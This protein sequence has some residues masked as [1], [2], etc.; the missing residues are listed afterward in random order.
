MSEEEKEEIEDKLGEFENLDKEGQMTVLNN[1]L[2]RYDKEIEEAESEE[3]KKK[4][5]LKKTILE[6]MKKNLK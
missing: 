3:V 1:V 2:E 4:I 6:K 5:E